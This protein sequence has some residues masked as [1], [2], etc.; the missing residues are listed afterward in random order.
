MARDVR[1]WS[2]C[3]SEARYRGP[4]MSDD[5]ASALFYIEVY[6]YHGLG[7]MCHRILTIFL[8]GIIIFLI[9]GCRREGGGVRPSDAVTIA[10]ASEPKH[11]NPLLLTDLVSFSVSGLIFRGLTKFDRNM[12]IV[13]DMADSWEILRG[14]HEIRFYLKKGVLWHDGVEL[15]AD[16]VVFTY[17]TVTSPRTAT[18]YSS[19]FGSATRVKAVDRYTVSVS[20]SVPYGSALESWMFGII[21]KHILH[22][23]DVL[24]LSFDRAPVGTGPYRLKQWLSGR[25]MW[26]ESF[27]RHYDGR[28]GIRNVILR[29]IPDAATQIMELKAGGIDV[30][31][32]TPMQYQI[33]ANA[34]KLASDFIK[35]RKGSF[36]Y[37]FLGLNLLDTRFQDVRVR[38]AIS[39]AID[40]RAIITS[41]L[42]GLGSE[43]S[44]PYPPEAWY[45]SPHAALFAYDP[46]KARG[47]LESAG[48]KKGADGVLR[49]NGLVMSFTILTNYESKE[50]IKTAQL[51]QSNLKAVG[52]ETTIRSLEW[53]TF[54]HLVIA[55]HQ[56]ES[57]VL[58]RA[59]LWNPDIYDL[60]HSSK[61][62]EGGWNFLSYKNPALDALL[63]RGRRTIAKKERGEIY[64]KVHEMLAE[65]QPSVFLYNADLL[66][67]SH[68]RI[69]GIEPSP[70]GMLQDI[71]RWKLKRR[72]TG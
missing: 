28:P 4:R 56:F 17:Q 38:Q 43:S 33:E 63:E 68:R 51:I 2:L 25:Q 36:R 35:H 16:D 37:G 12:T 72:L 41:V 1:H 18:P 60:W 62:G 23:R 22:D 21:P 66:F 59:Y 7:F 71:A 45:S 55:K 46:S 34:G 64:R 49:K 11:L 54:R 32:L 50:N 9:I 5:S 6:D 48:W 3:A 15:T 29:L 58:S 30:M 53:Q 40:K 14:G 19:H 44:G 13:P 52:I 65:E 47:L 8:A 10:I 70:A 24:D 42:M 27:D 67:I 26:L 39:H 57:V 31:E 20:Y 61:T 69:N